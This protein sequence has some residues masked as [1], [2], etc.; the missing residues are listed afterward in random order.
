MELYGKRYIPEK[1]MPFPIRFGDGDA[2]VELVEMMGKR[3]ELE[4]NCPTIG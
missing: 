4:L 3:E 2:V 1:E